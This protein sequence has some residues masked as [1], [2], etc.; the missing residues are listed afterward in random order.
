MEIFLFCKI[1]HWTKNVLSNSPAPEAPLK[2]QHI[3][4]LAFSSPSVFKIYKLKYHTIRNDRLA[5]HNPLGGC[6]LWTLV[7][8]YLTSSEPTSIGISSSGPKVGTGNWC[9]LAG[10]RFVFSQSVGAALCVYIWSLHTFSSFSIPQK[11]THKND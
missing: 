6:S 10:E 2:N 5:S 11:F 3:T 7:H 8:F 9:R 4:Y 1:K